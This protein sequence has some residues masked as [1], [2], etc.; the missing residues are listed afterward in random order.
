MWGIRFFDERKLK[1]SIYSEKIL[2]AGKKKTHMGEAQSKKQ[3]AQ[4]STPTV[5]KSQAH[6]TSE[7]PAFLGQD[8]SY[9]RVEVEIRDTAKR[10]QTRILRTGW[11]D[12]TFSFPEDSVRIIYVDPTADEYR[13][14]LIERGVSRGRIE[15][16]QAEGLY[17]GFSADPRLREITQQGVSITTLEDELSKE[18]GDLFTLKYSAAQYVL[19]KLASLCEAWDTTIVDNIINFYPYFDSASKK[20]IERRYKDYL[21]FLEEQ[22]REIEESMEAI[23]KN[24]SID[25]VERLVQ[26]LNEQ[27]TTL[28]REC[29]RI[30]DTLRDFMWYSPGDGGEYFN[31]LLSPEPYS[32]DQYEQYVQRLQ[33]NRKVAEERPYDQMLC[34]RPGEDTVDVVD[35]AKQDLGAN[36]PTY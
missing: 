8:K 16:S 13:F 21:N 25:A 27:L 15:P 19:D 18:I 7:T 24:F 4:Q 35:Y 34:P 9:R 14:T 12:K 22:Y 29:C 5:K 33:Q 36:T 23:E 3:F 6:T 17:L 1:L 26:R 28:D 10:I 31:P 2:L 20:S 32:K 30:R 11:D